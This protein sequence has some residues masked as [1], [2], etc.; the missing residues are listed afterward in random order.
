MAGKIKQARFSNTD[1]QI[2]IDQATEHKLNR[3]Q[4]ENLTFD[5][6]RS[7]RA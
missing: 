6:Y 4:R 3:N 2:F 5:Q 7:S 1:F